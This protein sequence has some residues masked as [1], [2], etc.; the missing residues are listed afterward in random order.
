MNQAIEALAP[1]HHARAL[2]FPAY[3]CQSHRPARIRRADARP[4]HHVPYNERRRL[5]PRNSSPAAPTLAPG[6]D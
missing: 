3:R 4:L 2:G 1:T 5:A 6:A